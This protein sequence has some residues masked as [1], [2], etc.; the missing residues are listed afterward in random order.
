MVVPN[1]QSPCSTT[2][3]YRP[4]PGVWEWM[5]AGA[6]FWILAG[7]LQ[8]KAGAFAA[9]FGSHP[10]EAAHYVTG[11]MIRD[12]VVTGHF[13]H[14]WAYA[15]YYYAHYPK[16]ALGMWPPLFHLTEALWTL[17]LSPSKVS[18]L[19]LE[20]LIAAALAA[21]VYWVLRRQYPATAAF[22]GGTL[23]VLLP[24]VRNS[25]QAVMADGLVALLA[26]WAMI[27]MVA[28][29]ERE[30]TRDAVFFGAF[31]ALSMTTK[32]NGVALVLLPVIAVLITRRFC[33]LR[34]SG[35]YYAAAIILGFGAPW[36]GFRKL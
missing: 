18:V 36:C 20:A 16:L 12:Y 14:P 35:L 2:P 30:R 22:A 8:W 21:S 24:L 25:T 34:R 28:Y 4:K 17:V 33:L 1:R 19:L 29:L 3:S 13:A 6:I 10:D 23:F 15:Q 32:A 31:A 9:E 11:L 27:F 5:V 7:C 26:F